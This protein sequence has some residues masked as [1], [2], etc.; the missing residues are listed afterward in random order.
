MKENNLHNR[1]QDMEHRALSWITERLHYFN[2]LGYTEI[3]KLDLALKASAELALVCECGLS[4][5]GEK[6]HKKYID[7][8]SFIWCEVFCA[9]AVRDYLLSTELG[10][11]TF[12]FYASLR[13][14]GYQDVEFERRLHRLLRE[15]YVSVAE[16]I[17][18]RDLDL[19]HSLTRL[20]LPWKGEPLDRIY[21]RCLLA[22]H[23]PIYPLT[24]DDVYAITHDIF[25][26]T[27]FGRTPGCFSD[28]DLNYLADLLPK[29]L[30]FYLRKGN[31]DLVAEL[32]ICM[33]ATDL[34]QLD[35]YCDGWGLLLNSQQPDGSFPGP[36]GDQA[37]RL[38]GDSG[39][40][41]TDPEWLRFH[42]N[43]HT[44]LVSI[45]GSHVFKSSSAMDQ[46]GE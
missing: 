26:V 24:V 27:D 9:P 38:W 45:L 36:K 32:L 21:S 10:L 34:D 12:G 5:H 44:T 25:F 23:P 28:S 15:G 41:D 22:G 19:L 46:P 2:P 13:R 16:R 6:S 29:L 14:Y 3:L 17:P 7:I 20:G 42:D 37:G 18:T 11:L 39:R 33:T 40:S 30:Q 1:T 43:Y 31:W 8:S 4:Q 35:V